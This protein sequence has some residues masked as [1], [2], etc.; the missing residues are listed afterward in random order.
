[1]GAKVIRVYRIC[2]WV[3]RLSTKRVIFP[4]YRIDLERLRSMWPWRVASKQP[5]SDQL[6]V[7]EALQRL[8]VWKGFTYCSGSCISILKHKHYGRLLYGQTI[9]KGGTRTG[10]S[11]GIGRAI[12]VA[13]CREGIDVAVNYFSREERQRWPASLLKNWRAGSAVRADV[14]KS[15]EVAEMITTFSVSLERILILVNNAGTAHRESLENIREEDWDRVIAVNLKSAFLWPRLWFPACGRVS[16]E[17]SSISPP[18]PHKPAYH[19]SDLRCVQSRSM[20]LTHSYASL[21]IKEG[22]TANTIS[23][24]LIETDMVKE[25]K[26]TPDRIPVGRFGESKRSQK[27]SPCS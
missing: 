17:E 15:S 13:N 10:A 25:I 7:K 16:G 11:R 3:C 2:L 27:S 24:A 21:L 1:M 14:S 22:I 6:K 20:G 26:A 19:C 5:V 23:P 18:L 9:R 8:S 4:R 12:A